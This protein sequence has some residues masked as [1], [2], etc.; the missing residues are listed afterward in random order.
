LDPALW[1]RFDEVLFFPRP[2][3]REIQIL[4]TMKLKNFPHSGLNLKL[5]ASKFKGF[6]HAD[7][8][9][10]CFDAIKIAI[11]EDKD[12]LDKNLFGQ[13]LTR[14]KIRVAI[15]KDAVKRGKS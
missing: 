14:H 12:S 9:R 5:A 2:S 15:A 11:L 7:V 8:E 10:V 6:S 1:R 3:L 13:A 4:L